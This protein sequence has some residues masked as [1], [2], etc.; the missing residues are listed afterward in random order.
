MRK[1]EREEGGGRGR[2]RRGR[3][4]RRSMAGRPELAGD[5]LKHATKLGFP[6]QKLPEREEGEGK[7][8]PASE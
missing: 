7:T 2:R 8:S 6:N 3:R 5:V 4:R 1:R